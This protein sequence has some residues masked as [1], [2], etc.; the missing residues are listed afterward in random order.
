MKSNFKL[1]E[2]FSCPSLRFFPR[3]FFAKASCCCL[4]LLVPGKL[5]LIDAAIFILRVADGVLTLRNS[6][7]TRYPERLYY[8][9][10]SDETYGR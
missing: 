4:S 6:A 5:A 7:Y 1:P 8:V 9:R 10:G 2:H 3:K